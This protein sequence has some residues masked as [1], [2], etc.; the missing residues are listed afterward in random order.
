MQ[1]APQRIG[2]FFL[3]LCPEDK[4]KN[5]VFHLPYNKALIAEI[6]GMKSATFSRALNILRQKTGIR[7]RD[8]RV[9]SWIQK[10]RC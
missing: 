1:N 8:T 6:L 5:I 3:S 10:S 2:C 7:I 4:K 9:E